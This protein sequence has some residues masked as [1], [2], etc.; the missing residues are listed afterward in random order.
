M[1]FQFLVRGKLSMV[2]ISMSKHEAVHPTEYD[3]DPPRVHT[4]LDT[5][6]HSTRCMNFNCGPSPTANVVIPGIHNAISFHSDV[7]RCFVSRVRISCQLQAS[8]ASR[9]AGVCELR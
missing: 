4:L 5:A 6:G 1:I 7:R 8:A 2:S 9:R 3:P